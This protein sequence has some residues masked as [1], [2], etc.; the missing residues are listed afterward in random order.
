MRSFG[1]VVAVVVLAS[2]ASLCAAKKKP[3]VALKRNS[4]L[5]K[6]KSSASS[7][8]K[9]QSKY[10]E[11]EDD[12]DEDDDEDGFMSDDRRGSRRDDRRQAQPTG[13]PAETRRFSE[14]EID[15]RR[16]RARAS[17]QPQREDLGANHPAIDRTL[18]TRD[19]DDDDDDER[20]TQVAPYYRPRRK[21][22]GPTV[23]QRATALS[24]RASRE[25]FS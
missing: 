4:A 3:S 14:D 23:W 12:E 7:K 5:H 13:A 10:D 6:K 9:R 22:T 2:C 1:G 15:A 18:P 16:S 11:D 24:P 20:W 17:R 8:S 25:F 19:D 21:P